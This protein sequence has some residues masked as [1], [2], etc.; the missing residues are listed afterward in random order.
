MSKSI[1]NVV[2]VAEPPSEQFGK[3]MSIRDSLLPMYLQYV[4]GWDQPQIDEVVADLAAGRTSARDAKRAMARAVCDLYHG[5]GAGET[6]Q[7]EFDR[8]FSREG[9][10]PTDVPEHAIGAPT[11]LSA[12]LRDAALVSSAR[13]AA[14]KI[15]EGAV[16]I[17]GEKV[18]EDRELDP[19][20]D[21]G[22]LV[23]VGKRAWVRVVGGR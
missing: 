8:V 1:G 6:A 19:A 21:H 23:Q 18:S 17:D 4:T 14:R 7:A 16:R 20:G 2:G 9:A 12:I 10:V 11:R 15:G 3:L 5:P 13:E 22:A